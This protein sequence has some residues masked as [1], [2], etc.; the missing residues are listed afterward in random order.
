MLHV[1][2]K[3]LIFNGRLRKTRHDFLTKKI[4]QFFFLVCCDCPKACSK[5]EVNKTQT[6]IAPCFS[7][8]Y[9]GHYVKSKRTKFY[10]HTLLESLWMKK[11][12]I[13]NFWLQNDKDSVFNIKRE[14]F[15]LFQRET[16]NASLSNQPVV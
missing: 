14:F 7:S 12:M 6:F 16:S 1:I 3:S 4:R 9:R 10:A 13:Y 5:L 15:V 2:I 11:V 8:L